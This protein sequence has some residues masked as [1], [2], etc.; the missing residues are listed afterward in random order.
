MRLGHDPSHSSTFALDA[1][2]PFHTANYVFG[3]PVHHE[4]SR[5][6]GCGLVFPGVCQVTWEAGPEAN[7]RPAMADVKVACSAVT[8]AEV[9][10]AL[11]ARARHTRSSKRLRTAEG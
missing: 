7:A 5:A 9:L 3:Q 6:I 2:P 11:F 8:S 4:A 10:D 1:D